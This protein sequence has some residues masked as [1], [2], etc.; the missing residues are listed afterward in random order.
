[1]GCACLPA[2]LASKVK[3]DRAFVSDENGRAFLPG[4]QEIAF[5]MSRLV[6]GG[7]MGRSLIDKDAIFYISYGPAAMARPAAL[8]F[9]A[10]QIKP[11]AY[12]VSAADLSVDETID[13]FMADHGGTVLARQ[14][15]DDLFG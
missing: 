14:P 10:R 12:V 9:A 6:A 4:M 3:R 2:C 1:M 13:A 8:A 11:P 15:S 5:P 7:N